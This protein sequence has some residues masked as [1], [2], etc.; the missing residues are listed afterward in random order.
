MNSVRE[1]AC[2][3]HG[4]A[5]HSVEIRECLELLGEILNAELPASGLSARFL[6]IRRVM[7]QRFAAECE[8]YDDVVVRSPWIAAQVKLL[9][10]WHQQIRDQLIQLQRM[11][12]DSAEDFPAVGSELGQQLREHELSESALRHEVFGHHR[13]ALQPLDI[14]GE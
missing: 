4:G 9:R 6:R 12:D 1:V 5:P 14:P 13:W 8:L 10:T 2:G 11:R 7:E 3:W